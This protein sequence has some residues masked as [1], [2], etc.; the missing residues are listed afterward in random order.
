[1]AHQW[2]VE[3]INE[4][5]NSKQSPDKGLRAR[6][7]GETYALGSRRLLGQENLTPI[8]HAQRARRSGLQ[9][10]IFSGE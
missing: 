8:N 9:V 4:V 7:A 1:M 10:L 3:T 6:I 2:D 5:T